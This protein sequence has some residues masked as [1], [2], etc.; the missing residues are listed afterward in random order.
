MQ[1]RGEELWDLML[2]EGTPQVQIYLGGEPMQRLRWEPENPTRIKH[3]Q[4][5]IEADDFRMELV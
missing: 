3:F 2:V 1:T 4:N 5:L